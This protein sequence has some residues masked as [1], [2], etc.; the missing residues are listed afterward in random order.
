MG[1]NHFFVPKSDL[2]EPSLNLIGNVLLNGEGTPLMQCILAQ[3]IARRHT[4]RL[5]IVLYKGHHCLIDD[6]QNIIDPRNDWSCKKMPDNFKAHP[7]SEQN[8]LLTVVSRLYLC[9]LVEGQLKSLHT[10]T[11]IMS[12]LSQMN[13]EDLPYPV[14]NTFESE[15]P[16]PEYE[17]S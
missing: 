11:K 10:L 12:S 9:S 5:H 3:F 6:Q 17:S 2:L 8:I 16:L 1:E 4:H 13:I 15:T 14:G 7:C